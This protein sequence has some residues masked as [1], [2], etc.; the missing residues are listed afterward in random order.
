L[1]IDILHVAYSFDDSIFSLELAFKSKQK[2]E[3]IECINLIQSY[4]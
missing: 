2:Y 1:F 3:N 4:I